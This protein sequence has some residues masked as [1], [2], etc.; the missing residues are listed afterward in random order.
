MISDWLLEMN[1]ITTVE[2]V[3]LGV[4][5]WLSGAI[6]MWTWKTPQPAN[7]SPVWDQQEDF[8][9][10]YKRETL[11]GYDAMCAQRDANRRAHPPEPKVPA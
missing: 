7:P 11:K 2:I 6:C 9:A 3:M 10:Y 4:V 5:S 1:Q 8:D